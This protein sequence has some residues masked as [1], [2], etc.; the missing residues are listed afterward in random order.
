MW[1]S[2]L[3]FLR[4]QKQERYLPTAFDE[5]L[6][7][8]QK[9]N[10]V[11]ESLNMII[12]NVNLF[13]EYIDENVNNQNNKIIELRDDFEVLKEWLEGEGLELNTV[14]VLN[15]WFDDGRLAQIINNE[16][17]DMK[18]DKDYVEGSLNALK[19]QKVDQV[20]FDVA[21]QEIKF[22]A[23]ENLINSV[24]I[25]EAANAS[26]VQDYID[27]LV[28]DGI[29]EGVTLADGSVVTEKYADQSITN[30]K[31]GKDFMVKVP[32]LDQPEDNVDYMWEESNRMIGIDTKNNPFNNTALVNAKRFKTLNTSNL[33][34]IVQEVIESTR[35]SN[36][37]RVYRF[38]QVNESTLEI[39]QK[40]RWRKILTD[41]VTIDDLPALLSQKINNVLVAEGAYDPEAPH[42][43]D[44]F[45][46]YNGDWIE[47]NNFDS[48]KLKVE[49]LE[50]YNIYNATLTI[51]GF[52]ESGEPT[53]NLSSQEQFT[54]SD[55]NTSY[56]TIPIRKGNRGITNLTKG[57]YLPERILSFGESQTRIVN[58]EDQN[59]EDLKGL[60][61]QKINNILVTEGA[62]D[63]EAPHE[64]D[65]FY[66]NSGEW[67]ER[68]EFDSYRL[69]VDYLDQYNIYNTTLT[70]IGFDEN[71]Q[72]TE[73]LSSQGQ[74][75]I[76]NKNTSYITIPI[77][78][79]NRGITNFTKGDYLPDKILS[80]GET[81]TR[82][83]NFE[84]QDNK[85][86]GM[87]WV[88]LGT[89]MT[90]RGE[91]VNHV[92]NKL[93]LDLDNRGVGSGGIT[94]HA[95]AGNTTMQAVESI[96]DFKGIVSIEVGPND[97]RGCPLGVLGDRNESTWYGAVDKVC[98]T[99]S[100]R[101]SA[102]AFFITST[103]GAFQL[104]ADFD[105]SKR[106]D[107]YE[108]NTHGHKY[109][110]YVN[111]VKEVAQHYSIPVCDV[112]GESGLGS[113]HMNDKTLSDHIH[114]TDLGG[115]IW[116]N[117][118]AN[119]LNYKFA[120]FPNNYENPTI[121]L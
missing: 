54:I 97:W 49:H 59:I 34:W 3:P 91:Y 75:T 2:K 27:A 13:G 31:F 82:L 119:F 101:T 63:P 98:R 1:F 21:T 89:S 74:F 90:S 7:L 45:Y 11:I 80:F 4:G 40:R 104:Q 120:P 38:I 94:T 42:E 115:D 81:Q 92:A 18:A 12:E 58:L 16:V 65:G 66:G 50:Q 9:V 44:G 43:L 114:L 60:V 53:E 51:V 33:V 32:W 106:R 15:E 52:N 86:V 57:D 107:L 105:E 28:A 37:E 103:T 29:I 93:S 5:S 116:G 26:L 22:Y 71:D 110:E 36:A 113:Y 23:N 46:S 55:E 109:I 48:Y 118:I 17:L 69:D 79:G 77:R 85:Y 72:V 56:I 117:H 25:T 68:P 95:S 67:I 111:A 87:R 88:A 70:I 121:N 84:H 30:E 41:S 64:L 19:N 8:L 24:D 14:K 20:T 61:S 39:L 108:T 102:R 6:T 100:Q 78:K 73:N 112:F 47:D 76:T 62:Y 35:A 99:I 10:K 83:I 96:E